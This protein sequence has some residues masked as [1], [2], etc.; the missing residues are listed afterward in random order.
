MYIG[1]TVI[2]FFFFFLLLKEEEKKKIWR[3]KHSDPLLAE[4]CSRNLIQIR[5]YAVKFISIPFVIFVREIGAF[6]TC[7]F[8]GGNV[9]INRN[10]LRPLGTSTV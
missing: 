1:Y 9:C 3:E 10:P 7:E 5:A 2:F 6:Y 4:T 8:R